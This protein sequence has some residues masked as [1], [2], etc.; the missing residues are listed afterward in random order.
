MGLKNRLNIFIICILSTLTLFFKCF[1]LLYLNETDF[2][3][4]RNLVGAKFSTH[5]KKGSK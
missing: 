1:M 4:Q 3:L 5:K 2:C